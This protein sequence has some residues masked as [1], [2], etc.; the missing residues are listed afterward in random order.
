MGQFSWTW[1]KEDRGKPW[2]IARVWVSVISKWN[3]SKGSR[4]LKSR[5]QIP[6]SLEA[7]LVLMFMAT[8]ASESIEVACG[9]GGPAVPA[10]LAV[11]VLSPSMMPICCYGQKWSAR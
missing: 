11:T 1:A 6:V 4:L 8:M 3:I 2:S 9:A 10:A 7:S 5:D